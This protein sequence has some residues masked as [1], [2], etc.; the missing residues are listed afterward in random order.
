MEP[1]PVVDLETEM[2]PEPLMSMESLDD[3][4]GYSNNP[5]SDSEFLSHIGIDG[6]KIPD[7]FKKSKIAKWVRDGML[8]QN[9]FVNALQFLDKQ[10]FL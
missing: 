5:I 8:T 6:E 2:D 1:E 10:G 7:W 9:E 4:A 3:W